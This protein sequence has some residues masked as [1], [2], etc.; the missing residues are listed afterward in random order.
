LLFEG[1][2]QAMIRYDLFS[3][4]TYVLEIFFAFI[5]TYVY[6]AVSEQP[7]RRPFLGLAVGLSYTL[8]LIVS[9][10]MIEGGF[11]HPLRFIET[12]IFDGTFPVLALLLVWFSLEIGGLLAALFYKYLKYKNTPDNR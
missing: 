11:V 10:G 1:V 3:F 8:V 4:R 6:L 5:V 7:E 9:T 12:F 2:N